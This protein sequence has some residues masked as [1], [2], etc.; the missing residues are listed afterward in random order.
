MNLDI[1][2]F[3]F[4]QKNEIRVLTAIEMGMRNHDWVP[5]KLIEKLANLKRGN[6]YK[7][8]QHLLK[9]KLI[10]H[11]GLN[12][13]GYRLNFTGY[14]YLALNVFY[15]AGLISKLEMKIGVGKES[16]IYIARSPENKILV[17]KLARLG[18]T[19]F[20]SIKEKRDYLGKKTTA[21]WLYLSKISSL[22]EFKFMEALYEVN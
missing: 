11:T 7:T 16:D 2:Y 15:K 13:D 10:A 4:L 21:N 9:H 12:Y 5:A 22:K 17:L 1:S 14:D 8:I 20:R 3:E 18:R 19:S 6:A